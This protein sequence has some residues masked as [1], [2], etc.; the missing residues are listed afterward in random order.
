MHIAVIRFASAT[1]ESASFCRVGTHCS[2]IPV[3]IWI[4]KIRLAVRDAMQTY[5][6]S[7]TVMPMTFSSHW[8]HDLWCRLLSQQ[9]NTE[10][11]RQT[12]III[13]FR[14]HERICEDVFLSY[15]VTAEN[16]YRYRLVL[17]ESDKRGIDSHGLGR[18]NPSTATA[19]TRNLISDRPVERLSKETGQPPWWQFGTR[20]VHLDLLA[21]LAIDKAKKHGVGFWWRA[22]YSLWYRW[23]LY[24]HGRRPG[25]CRQQEPTRPSIAATFGR[26]PCRNNHY[27]LAYHRMIPFLYYD[28]ATSGNQRGKIER[29]H[30]RAKPH[31]KDV[32]MTRESSEPTLKGSCATW[33]W[34]SNFLVPVGAREELGGYKGYR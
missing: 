24:R 15:G 12:R 34:V 6:E 13:D 25:L 19:W 1:T 11:K 5:A 4:P 20:T 28:C 26:N 33:F 30:A 2:R 27:V 32:W 7:S 17:I 3:D 23:L 8:I 9:R 18:S 31:H 22:K 16:A 14:L 21:Q 10:S 29:M